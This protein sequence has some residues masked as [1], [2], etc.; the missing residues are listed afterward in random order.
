MNGHE[1]VKRQLAKRGIG[2]EALDNGIVRCD[3][4]AV[5]TVAGNGNVSVPEQ[6]CASMTV[7]NAASVV[8]F[9]KLVWR[10]HGHSWRLRFPQN[11]KTERLRNSALPD[12]ERGEREAAGLG[13]T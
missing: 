9:I 2:F 11:L 6:R 1:Y 13:E 3:T 8:R 5:E 12:I 10:R 4:I 7:S